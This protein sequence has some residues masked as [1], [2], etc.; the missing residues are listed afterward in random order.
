[1]PAP[2]RSFVMLGPPASG[3]GT[4]GRLLAEARGLAYLSTGARLRREIE[5]KSPLGQEAQAYLDRSQYVPDELAVRLVS[6]WLRKHAEGWLLD[7]FPRS[8]PQAEA[9]VVLAGDSFSAIHLEVD[10]VDLRTRVVKR[11]ECST[12]GMVATEA[13]EQCPKCGSL[14]R[15]RADDSIEA[16]EKRLSAYEQLTIPAVSFLEKK[17]LLISVDGSGSR[18]EVAQTIRERLS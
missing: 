2:V 3:K 12:C 18:D 7:G 16:F 11:R 8:I 15:T 5:Q 13:S 9:L 10:S 14:L 4:Q 1:M 17:G 6:D